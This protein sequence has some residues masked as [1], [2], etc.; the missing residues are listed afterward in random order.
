MRLGDLG[1]DSR[2][3]R[4]RATDRAPNA[5]RGQARRGKRRR[6]DH[7]WDDE[8]E[9]WPVECILDA[10][11]AT[12]SDLKEHPE[13]KD[14][15]VSE[16]DILYLVAWEGW[17]PTYNSWEPYI[18]IADDDLIADYEE[19]AA[20]AQDKAEEEAEEIAEEGRAAVETPL[21]M[22]HTAGQASSHTNDEMPSGVCCT[23]AVDAT[24]DA[25]QLDVQDRDRLL[26][27]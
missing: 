1:C 14:A 20:A 21:P 16:G 27:A 26:H 17:D 23:G 25:C 4:R 13:W 2:A 22:V 9:T 12:G 5:T 8:Q 3:P 18:Y 11:P 7:E 19:R 6:S 24:I 10:R 15:D